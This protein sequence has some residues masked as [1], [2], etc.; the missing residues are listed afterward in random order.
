MFSVILLCT[1][2]EFKFKPND[3]VAGRGAGFE[4]LRY[5]RLESRYLTTGDFSA[6]QQMNTVYPMETRTLL[7]DMLQLGDVSNPEVNSRF[8]NL[9]QDTTLQT[10]IADAETQYASMRDIDEQLGRAFGRLAK[11]IPG[12]QTPKVYAQIGAFGQ[13]I[14]I[15]DQ[16]IGISLDKYLGKD[17]AIYRRYYA[18][19][20]YQTMSREYIVPD[21]LVFYLVSLYPLPGHDKRSQHVKDLHMGKVMW[22]V[23]QALGNHFFKGANVSAIASYM[24]RNPH[25]GIP[26][27]LKSDDYS[28]FPER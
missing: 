8:L 16:Y 22:V 18:P 5:D 6:L 28:V 1:A 26:E 9:Y 17:Y 7:E 24:K 3:D 19:A 27:L 13:S 2:C 25:V 23:N 12:F 4:V 10:V 11:L 15:G 20:Q 14:V 21:C